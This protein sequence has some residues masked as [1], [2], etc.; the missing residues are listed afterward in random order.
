MLVQRD[1][2]SE[3]LRSS[4]LNLDVH[5]PVHPAPPFESPPSLAVATPL[6]T[7]L[8]RQTRTG[9]ASH[10]IELG[11]LNVGNSNSSNSKKR[12][13]DDDDETDD[14]EAQVN[15]LFAISQRVQAGSLES[16]HV[17][18]DRSVVSGHPTPSLLHP[19]TWSAPSIPRHHKN[20]HNTN[21]NS[22]QNSG[23]DSPA[24]MVHLNG[25]PTSSEYGKGAIARTTSALSTSS[26][27]AGASFTNGKSHV[28]KL[29][30]REKER[31]RAMSGSSQHSGHSGRFVMHGEGNDDPAPDEHTVCHLREYDVHSSKREAWKMKASDWKIGMRERMH[32]GDSSSYHQADH[33]HCDDPSISSQLS[34]SLHSQPSHLDSH[35]RPVII[36]L[37]EFTNE[38][39]SM[40]L[41]ESDTPTRSELPVSMIASTSSPPGLNGT[42][43][44]TIAGPSGASV[45]QGAPILSPISQVTSSPRSA[46]PVLNAPGYLVTNSRIP[47]V[48]TVANGV[49]TSDPS[50]NGHGSPAQRLVPIDSLTRPLLPGDIALTTVTSAFSG[51]P[52][53]V[54]SSSRNRRSHSSA[55]TTC[56]G[57][58][59]PPTA[60][61]SLLPPLQVSHRT[62][63][64]SMVTSPESTAAPYDEVE[65]SIAAQAEVIR[66][67]RQEKRAEKETGGDNYGTSSNEDRSGRPGAPMIKRRST[68]LGSGDGPGTG[69]LVGNLIGQDHANYVLM[70]NMLTG[71][72]IGVSRCQAKLKRPLTD[73]DYTARH[74]FSFDIVGNEL[75]PSVKYDFKFKDYAP[76]VFRELR[77]YFYLDPSDYLVSLT[78]KY[79]LSELGSPGK[80]GSFFYF[81]RD[82]RFI[83]KTIRHAE[84]KFLRSILKQ[85]HEYIKENPHTLLSRFYGLHRVKLPR[86]RKIHF[87]IMNNLFPPHRDIHET[88]DLKGSAIGRKTPDEKVQESSHAILKD[89]NWIER[90]RQLDLGPEKKALFEEQLRRDTE[91]MQKLR[92]MDYSLLTGIHNVRRGN[93]DNL[94]DNMLT[95][96]QPDTFK[97]PRRKLTDAKRDFDAAAVR[98][99]VQQSDPKALSE[100]NKLPDQDT[101]ERRMFLFYQDE[102]GIR[103]T[104]DCNE[105]L[106]VIYYL[107]IIDILT[108]YTFVKKV[109]HYWKSFKHNGHMISA[110]PPEEYGDRFMAFIYSLIRGNDTSKRPKMYEHDP[111]PPSTAATKPK[112]E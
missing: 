44:N 55:E 75:T 80:S 12:N 59:S 50:M 57:Y 32:S 10:G 31:E 81:S 99:A 36:S 45:L 104:G 89:L 76:W 40:V 85:Y 109:E 47:P 71:I 17:I 86:G 19:S 16:V 5:H 1:H 93:Q 9:S 64:A 70:Y 15:P 72:R 51:D 35:E 22:N 24:A 73:A 67:K 107:G 111:P 34:R 96:F 91:L 18:D 101:S 82:Y 88:Y 79:I 62:M 74:K 98:K 20:N 53:S 52:S 97:T 112:T 83:I 7:S 28:S 90:G 49:S 48:P 30:Q 56:P 2:A 6:D 33:H 95:V 11:P 100:T 68:R 46:I 29:S 94:R 39:V 3:L 26:S 8:A 21:N 60:T 27:S 78:A 63:N 103:A 110:V 108:P 65:S 54:S 77:E 102:G 43:S 13:D 37:N 42:P 41:P 14:E 84:H 61:T 4:S 92:I 58:V 23:K 87:V 66:K 25:A 69:V 105:D 38:P 106:G